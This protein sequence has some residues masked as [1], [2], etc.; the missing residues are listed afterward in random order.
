MIPQPIRA[1][2]GRRLAKVQQDEGVRILLAVESGSRAWGFPSPDSDFDVRFVYCRPEPWY[3]SVDVE[4]KRDVLEHGITDDIDLNGWDLRKALRLLVRSNPTI[5]EWL[6]SPV[7]YLAQ[8]RFRR[9]ALELLG[10]AYVP[11]SG[12]HHYRSMA[13]TNY[14]GYLKAELVPLKKYFYVMRPLLA[15]RWIEQHHAAPPIEFQKLLVGLQDRHD[16]VSDVSALLEKKKV[17][18]E[19]DVAAPLPRL[20]GYIESELDRL[21]GFSKEGMASS[22]HMDAASALFRSLVRDAWEPNSA[23]QSTAAS[24]RG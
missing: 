18:A 20:N 14:R 16:L 19:M 7:E 13:R 12:I 11:A 2:I 5:V 3:Y 15:I 10:K 24:G 21:E 9:A 6:Q 23:L 22:H 8:G 17:S 4:E 1:E